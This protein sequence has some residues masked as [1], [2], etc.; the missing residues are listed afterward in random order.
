MRVRDAGVGSESSL[1][2]LGGGAGGGIGIGGGGL[3]NGIGPD[4]DRGAVGVDLETGLA[5]YPTAT[6]TSHTRNQSRNGAA[7]KKRLW[8]QSRKHQ[9]INLSAGNIAQ[10]PPS[11]ELRLNPPSRCQLLKLETQQRLRGRGGWKRWWSSLSGRQRLGLKL[12]LGVLV[13]GGVVGLAVG[14]W[15]RFSRLSEG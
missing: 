1:G 7:Q 6:R 8:S 12:L 14:L 9:S 4:G 15:W 2:T 3:G 5:I 11:S 13:V 10:P